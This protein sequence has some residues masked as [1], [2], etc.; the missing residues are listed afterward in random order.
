M[1]ICLNIASIQTKQRECAEIQRAGQDST[2]GLANLLFLI[3]STLS[4][5]MVEERI[6]QFNKIEVKHDYINVMEY[7]FKVVDKLKNLDN[8]EMLKFRNEIRT[9]YLI[10]QLSPE[11]SIFDEPEKIEKVKEPEIDIKKNENIDS[12][13]LFFDE[14]KQTYANTE[15]RPSVEPSTKIVEPQFNDK[16]VKAQPR[17]IGVEFE[18][19]RRE[20]Y[21][22]S[23]VDTFEFLKSINGE[24]RPIHEVIEGQCRFFVDIDDKEPKYTRAE[25]FNHLNFLM[26]AVA[27]YF[28]QFFEIEKRLSFNFYVAVSDCPSYNSAHI[29][30]DIFDVVSLKHYEAESPRMQGPFWSSF[31]KHMDKK[32]KKCN[33]AYLI[34][35]SVYKQK[36]QLRLPMTRKN[37][38]LLRPIIGEVKLPFYEFAKYE[39]HDEYSETLQSGFLMRELVKS[40]RTYVGGENKSYLRSENSP[41]ICFCANT[42]WVDNIEL[43]E[44]P[45]KKTAIRHYTEYEKIL[46]ER[47]LNF[48]TLDFTVKNNKS[49][50]KALINSAC[51]RIFCFYK[52]QALTKRIEIAKKYLS[53]FKV[54]Y[55][56]DSIFKEWEESGLYNFFNVEGLKSFFKY[57]PIK[58]ILINER[59]IKY[60]NWNGVLLLKSGTGTGKTYGFL[61]KVKDSTALFISCRISLSRE[62]EHSAKRMGIDMVNY[63]DSI[64]QKIIEL[65]P[66]HFCVQ[67]NS[68]HKFAEILSHYEYIFID[69][70]ESI[71]SSFSHINE[72]NPKVMPV[73]KS[74]MDKIFNEKRVVLC[75]ANLGDRT[76][77]FVES[78]KVPFY[79]IEN[80]IL[81]KDGYECVPCDKNVFLTELKSALENGKK[82]VVPVS[83]VY[84][85]VLLEK[86][87]KDCKVPNKQRIASHV[88]PYNYVQIQDDAPKQVPIK[89][90]IQTSETFKVAVNDWYEYDC[91]IYTST[92]ETG[93]SINYEFFDCIFGY[94]DGNINTYDSCYQMLFRVRNPKSKKIYIHTRQNG[95]TVMPDRFDTKKATHKVIMDSQDHNSTITK[96]EKIS[97]FHEYTYKLLN[98]PIDKVLI[99]NALFRNYSKSYFGSLLFAELKK[100][101]VLVHNLEVSKVNIATPGKEIIYPVVNSIQDA[102]CVNAKKYLGIDVDEIVNF[103]NMT[104]KKGL[105]MLCSIKNIAINAKLTHKEHAIKLL[106]DAI[107]KKR[108]EDNDELDK[109]LTKYFKENYNAL[110]ACFEKR[111][112][113]LEHLLKM[114]PHHKKQSVKGILSECGLDFKDTGDYKRFNLVM[115]EEI[116]NICD[117][118]NIPKI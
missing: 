63:S 76:F 105:A 62:F 67:L 108:Y 30:F 29:Y 77:M 101:G 107:G 19:E 17:A 49:N 89:I 70:S 86:Y 61:E 2:K 33:F 60:P 65:K 95:K 104:Q 64:P 103:G 23:L 118:Y 69:E 10:V 36:A 68:L 85:S 40:T 80:Q 7:S 39:Q 58:K 27:P 75:S 21:N 9:Q 96:E 50:N 46:F 83:C 74:M 38:Y 11:S 24:T 111:K 25:F 13:P 56:V 79:Y 91:V 45:K 37:G 100:A 114:K 42:Q 72:T 84:T 31:I 51:Y 113:S 5:L 47:I 54:K 22:H 35:L 116:S 117:K 109:V 34:D 99:S 93:V 28:A 48:S 8:K 110:Y 26:F 14:S 59:Y 53:L 16:L 87:L 52:T 98:D 94:F 97:V 106:V 41:L 15:Y 92:I 78:F 82:C 44:A 18:G 12:H 66:N 88:N 32:F 112:Y 4:Q 115:N 43:L 90:L 71:L 3:H 102:S 57:E 1:N 81:D 6:P 20:F 55:D 73:L